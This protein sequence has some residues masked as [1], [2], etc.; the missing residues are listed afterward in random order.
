M[1]LLEIVFCVF[2]DVYLYCVVLLLFDVV[3]R[4][5]SLVRIVADVAW[6]YGV[7]AGV[8]TADAVLHCGLV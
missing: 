2:G 3:V 7:D 8:I 4:C 1:V 6:E 5:T